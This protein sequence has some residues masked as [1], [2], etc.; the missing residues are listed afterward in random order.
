MGWLDLGWSICMKP[1]Q[2]LRYS[3]RGHLQR[4]INVLKPLIKWLVLITHVIRISSYTWLFSMLSL[5]T[6][7]DNPYSIMLLL[8][9]RKGF[10]ILDRIL[11]TKL[12]RWNFSFPALNSFNFVHIFIGHTCSSCSTQFLVSCQTLRSF[13]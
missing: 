4:L 2:L 1:I 7:Y 10:Y 3:H 6:L 13:N 9:L 12:L 8:S 11:T 5:W